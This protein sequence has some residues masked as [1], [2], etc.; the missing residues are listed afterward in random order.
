MRLKATRTVKIADL[1]TNLFVRDALD[2]N[3]VLYLAEL[4]ENGVEMN[5]LVEV[6][7]IENDL[8]VVDGRHRKDAYELNRIEEI[9]VK[10]LEFDDEAEMI[11]YAYRA[12]TGGSKP[13][14]AADTEHTVKLL[15]E[16][17]ESMKRIGELLGLPASMAR[18][19][20]NEVKS[21]MN[22]AKLQKAIDLVVASGYTAAKAAEQCE[23]DLEK[24]KE[25]LSGSR[26]NH[27]QGLQDLHRSLSTLYNGLGKKN[28]A[29]AKK[30]MDKFE[31]GDVTEKQVRD[32]FNHVEDLQKKAA[33]AF[34]DWKKRFDAR[35]AA[36]KAGEKATK[37]A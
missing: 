37:I 31:D 11:A 28:A 35:V 36:K 14:T 15:L 3:H 9:K 29:L 17:K 27:K 19:Y 7:E 16:R 25:A 18:R 21:R 26:K 8:N 34:S 1:Q 6:T 32:V 10:I 4:I 5:D 20:A 33:R 2:Q 23:V 30:F 13:P 22:R 12:N 24:L